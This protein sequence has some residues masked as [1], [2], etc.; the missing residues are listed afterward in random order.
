[1]R[2][3]RLHFFGECV[4][5]AASVDKHFDTLIVLRREVGEKVFKVLPHGAITDVLSRESDADFI[6]AIFGALC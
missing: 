3:A 2:D 1:M 6:A 4:S 5:F